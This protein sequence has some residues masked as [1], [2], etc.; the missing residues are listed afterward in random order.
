MPRRSRL[1]CAASSLDPQAA[2][3]AVGRAF[4]VA[5]DRF[6]ERYP[7]VEGED[8]AYPGYWLAN[9]SGD[10]VIVLASEHPDHFPWT[11]EQIAAALSD[12][13]IEGRFT[14][15]ST[16]TQA[17]DRCV[18]APSPRRPRRMPDPRER[19]QPAVAERPAPRSDPRPRRGHG[20]CV[21]GA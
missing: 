12:A 7:E 4:G 13:G 6:A 14:L 3:E 8:E 20:G 21:T 16:G 10:T 15:A 11:L 2:M 9:R 1:R 17:A 5:L 18:R 19:H